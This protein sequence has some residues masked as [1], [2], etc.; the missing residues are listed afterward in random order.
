MRLVTD[1]DHMMGTGGL[2]TTLCVPSGCTFHAKE[3]AVKMIL[4]AAAFG[5]FA[6]PALAANETCK[7]AAADKKLAGAAL[8]S[9]MTRCE[10]DATK[11][12]EGAAAD[13]KLVGAAKTA[14]TNKC[15]SDA[16][17]IGDASCKDTAAHKKLAGAALTSY[18]KKC[19]EDAT[20]SCNSAAADKNLSGAA[21]TSYTKKCVDDVV[22]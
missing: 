13:K 16:V 20:K 18:M 19:K 21:K 14:F 8:T 7:E 17:G 3:C 5:L 15:V 6:L 2:G 22:G 1:S 10:T 11:V 12:C 4:L 9:F